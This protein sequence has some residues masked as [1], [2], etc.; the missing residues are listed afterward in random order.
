MREGGEKRKREGSKGE[1]TAI[2]QK[3]IIIMTNLESPLKYRDVNNVNNGRE[4]SEFSISYISS[5]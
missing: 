1:K 4:D 3:F 5:F 2:R